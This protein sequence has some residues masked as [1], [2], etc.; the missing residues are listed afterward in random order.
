MI[1]HLAELLR[2]SEPP[3]F[4]IPVAASAFPAWRAKADKRRCEYA[5][6]PVG[7]G[8]HVFAND[9][10][11]DSPATVAT[12]TAHLALSALVD[13]HGQDGLVLSP[14]WLANVRRAADLLGSAHNGTGRGD[15][16]RGRC[17]PARSG[18]HQGEAALVVVLLCEIIS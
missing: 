1:Q 5:A 3:L 17:P 7:G 12:R 2:F 16:H 9:R 10:V 6:V 11:D 15:I 13:V 18:R 4:I 14:G 8:W